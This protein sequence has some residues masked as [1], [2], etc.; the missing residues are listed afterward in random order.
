MV[1]DFASRTPIC[2]ESSL[3]EKAQE[4][5]IDYNDF[6]DHLSAQK[7]D[8]EMADELG[9]STKTVEHLREHFEKVGVHNHL[10]QE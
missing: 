7:N 4:E 8:Q 3:K 2:P 6:L 10:G 5:N 9:V 1:E